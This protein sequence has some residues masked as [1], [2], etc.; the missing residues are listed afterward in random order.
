MN[1]KNVIFTK[2]KLLNLSIEYNIHS[3]YTFEEYKHHNISGSIPVKFLAG[4]YEKDSNFI[5]F[6]SSN[7]LILLNILKD[8][9]NIC[10]QNITS[11]EGVIKILQYSIFEDVKTINMNENDGYNIEYEMYS[12]EYFPALLIECANI[13]DFLDPFEFYVPLQ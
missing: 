4:I 5:K 1:M 8:F 12:G 2:N 6:M 13:K 11:N 10:E 7:R 9:L 3:Y